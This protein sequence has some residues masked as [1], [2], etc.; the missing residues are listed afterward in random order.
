MPRA[1]WRTHSSEATREVDER[2]VRER[3]ASS[4]ARHIGRRS[5]CGARWNGWHCSLPAH[6]GGTHVAAGGVSSM[7]YARW[8]IGRR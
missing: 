5:M 8:Y 3:I 1:R 6:H 4:T 7:I 2:C